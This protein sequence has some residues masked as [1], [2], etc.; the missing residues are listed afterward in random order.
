MQ[1]VPIGLLFSI[2]MILQSRKVS[3]VDQ[4]LISFASWPLQLKLL[5]APVI[6]SVYIKRLGRRKT[7]IVFIEITMAIFAIGSATYLKKIL[8]IDTERQRF[9]KSSG[10]KI[11]LIF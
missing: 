10:F 7:W 5:W 9:G 8:D 6:D 2:P 3:Y 4:G 1:T 11:F